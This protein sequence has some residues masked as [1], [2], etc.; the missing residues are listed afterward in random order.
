M[1]TFKVID[2]VYV[3]SNNNTYNIIARYTYSLIILIILSS[4]INIFI[5]NKS[6]VLSLFRTITLSILFAS[7]ISYIINIFKKKY[8]YIKI[9][10]EENTL[11]IA[12]IISLFGYN[13]NIYILFLA[14]LISFIIKNSFKNINNACVLYGILVIVIYSYLNNFNSLFN[15]TN[16]Y[17]M[18][19]NELKNIGILK[20][21]FGINYLVPL[22]SIITFIYLFYKKGIKYNL[23]LSYLGTFIFMIFL[24]GIQSNKIWLVLFELF[25]SNILFLSVF[26]LSDYKISPT[27]ANGQIIYGIVLGYMSAVFR[28]FMPELAIILPIIICSLLINRLIDK[29]SYKFKYDQ[30]KYYLFLAIS[31]LIMIITAIVLCNIYYL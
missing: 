19:F 16:N 28:F 5:G 13:T 25:T 22:L 9:Y 7:I 24:I 1:R 6:V 12:L 15:V 8:S 11:F 14:I 20:Y 18:T 17:T 27:I 23:I 3:K 2:K 21:L 29:I 26:T 4:I 30:K 31:L 10:T